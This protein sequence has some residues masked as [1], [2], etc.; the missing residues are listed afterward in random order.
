MQNYK[1]LN[2]NKKSKIKLKNI[3]FLFFVSKKNFYLH[4]KT[5]LITKH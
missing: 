5:E 1:Y 3:G 4:P 2:I